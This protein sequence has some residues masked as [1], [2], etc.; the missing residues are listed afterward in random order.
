MLIGHASCSIGPCPAAPGVFPWAPV[1]RLLPLLYPT[2][3]HSR[4]CCC[5]AV[6]PPKL[7]RPLLRLF[8]QQVIHSQ[9]GRRGGVCQQECA[10]EAQTGWGG[11]VGGVGDAEAQ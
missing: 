3:F 1:L 4:H 9:P 2:S 8:Q 5:I 7:L 10:C 6:L 11:G